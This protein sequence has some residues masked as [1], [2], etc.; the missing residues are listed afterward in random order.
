MAY[1]V[2]RE[3]FNATEGLNLPPGANI[4]FEKLCAI[5]K[6]D[7]GG[8]EAEDFDYD[9]DKNLIEIKRAGAYLILWTIR[10]Q[11][12]LPGE[13][14]VF[15]L[16]LENPDPLTPEGKLI[17][18]WFDVAGASTQLKIA[19]SVG[20]G[21]ILKENERD[22]IR[23]GLQNISKET[24]RLSASSPVQAQ[25][26]LY[27]FGDFDGD[28]NMFHQRLAYLENTWIDP[29]VIDFGTILSTLGSIEGNNPLQDGLI[30]NLKTDLE[31]TFE[32][33]VDL[34]SPSNV[35]DHES[36]DI[37]GLIIRCLRSENAYNFWAE[38]VFSGPAITF[39][40]EEI[41][42]FDPDTGTYVPA[43][44]WEDRVYLWRSDP[45]QMLP[46][47]KNPARA[48]SWYQGEPTIMAAWFCQSPSSQYLIPIQAGNPG[49][50]FLKEDIEDILPDEYTRFT[51]GLF[52]NDPD[53]A[54]AP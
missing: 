10:Q 4:P 31:D 40:N 3:Y 12:G 16:K 26:L 1:Y 45:L 25:I 36:P 5:S 49:L 7:P 44:V 23:L 29:E 35:F 24:V 43:G 22:H 19:D 47:E 15:Q 18:T 54:P 53:L 42:T 30:E 9:E 2:Q 51:F 20:T 48:L 46:E 52:L 33:L 27:G 17:P 8:P 41:H 28:M 37:P 38:G 11:T 50:Y 34:T 32:N 6:R 14:Q 13:G 39:A 21:F